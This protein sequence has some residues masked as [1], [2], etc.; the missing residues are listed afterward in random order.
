MFS[1]GASYDSGYGR[2]PMAKMVGTSR[3]FKVSEIELASEALIIQ[4]RKGSAP[5]KLDQ[6]AALHPDKSRIDVSDSP[7]CM[8]G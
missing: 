5:H 7:R 4:Y 2:T 8:L 1:I 3:R 6:E